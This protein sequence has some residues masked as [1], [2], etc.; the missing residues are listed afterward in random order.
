MAMPK[1]KGQSAAY[2]G[3]LT[4]QIL[5]LNSEKDILTKQLSDVKEQLG[6]AM[7]AG[8][9]LEQDHLDLQAKYDK[10][11]ADYGQLKEDMNK[12]NYQVVKERRKVQ[13]K[14][15]EAA[16]EAAEAAEKAKEELAALTKDRD[17][18]QSEIESLA[19]TLAD[20]QGQ[21]KAAKSTPSPPTPAQNPTPFFASQ[22][23]S[24]KANG[25]PI[26]QPQATVEKSNSILSSL[27][28]S[29]S[30]AQGELRYT[31]SDMNRG[32][33][34]ARQEQLEYDRAEAQ[35]HVHNLNA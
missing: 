18:K 33:V 11:I 34:A 17:E 10:S 28:G 27:R 1:T 32:I 7:G 31:Q 16:K 26:N 15:E 6:E 29:G 12:V 8:R 3:D 20:L 30:A 2:I 35:E 14:A 13:S 21:L 5:G 24:A 4:G 23:Q 9:K 22:N 25:A 19:R